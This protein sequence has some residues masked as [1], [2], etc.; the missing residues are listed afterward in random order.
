MAAIWLR[1][2]REVKRSWPG[3]Q[4][5][6]TDARMHWAYLGGQWPALGQLVKSEGAV[7]RPLHCP[8]LHPEGTTPQESSTVTDDDIDVRRFP[9]RPEPLHPMTSTDVNHI[10]NYVVVGELVEVASAL[11]LTGAASGFVGVANSTLQTQP[12]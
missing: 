5:R 4:I 11:R 10:W 3:S 9:L 6:S 12:C 8:H 1:L 7:R 2:S